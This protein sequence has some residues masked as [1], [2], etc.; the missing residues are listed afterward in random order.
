MTEVTSFEETR[1]ISD[2]LEA[3]EQKLSPIFVM[4]KAGTG[5]S[6]LIKHIKNSGRFKKVVVVAPT[7]VAALNAGGQTIHSFF[8]LPPRII[9]PRALEMRYKNKLWKR[10][11]IIIIDEVSMVRP[12]V[13][14]AIDH[15]LR[16]ARNSR[17]PFGGACVLFFG[18]FLQLPPIV[19]NQDAEILYQ[20]G[21]RAPYAL[22]AHV[23]KNA[24][25]HFMG[26]N[27]VYRQKDEDFLALL[28]NIRTGA[29]LDQTLEVLNEECAG[30]HRA[31]HV[32]ILLT[33]TNATA[34]RYNRDEMT[35]LSEKA[36]LF[37]AKSVGKFDAAKLRPPAPEKLELKIGARVIALRNDQT[38]RW[39]NGS[40]G[41]VTRLSSDSVHVQFDHRDYP[42]EIKKMVWENIKYTWDQKTEQV[43]SDVIGAY[44][45]IPLG[46]AWAMTIHKAQGLTLDD[47]RID[48]EG[49]SFSSGQTYVALSRAR[50]L[51]GLS[52]SQNLRAKDIIVDYNLINWLTQETDMVLDQ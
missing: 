46:L 39:V 13:I 40:L 41:T 36:A 29:Y 45:Q 47:V 26:L 14:D 51:A 6:T 31:G 43:K 48:L 28:S 38:R 30:P 37:T 17:E 3:V 19:P 23:F 5:K 42:L 52:F 34:N 20:M 1:E 7:G 24:S 9:D 8:Y 11:E 25:P 27:K 2:I 15:V 4:G 18:D 12:D 50:T 32:P 35:K 44:T 33:G 49:G 16:T 22:N 21:Y 10:A